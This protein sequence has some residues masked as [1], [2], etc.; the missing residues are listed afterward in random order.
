MVSLPNTNN[1]SGI[2]GILILI[3]V[4]GWEHMCLGENG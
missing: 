1:L 4:V 3:L 2:V